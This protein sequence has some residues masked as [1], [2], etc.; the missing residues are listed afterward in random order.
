MQHLEKFINSNKYKNAS[1]Q[2]TINGQIVNKGNNKID[3]LQKEINRFKDKGTDIFYKNYRD[4]FEIIDEDGNSKTL[5][6]FTMENE[7]L[8]DIFKRENKNAIPSSSLKK[9]EKLQNF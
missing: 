1:E 8:E 9:L 7:I 4:D 6:E 2:L 5:Y 3:L